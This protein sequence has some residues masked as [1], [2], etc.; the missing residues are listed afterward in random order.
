MRRIEKIIW[1]RPLMTTQDI[2]LKP[3]FISCAV[4]L[5][6]S[7]L[8]SLKPG[9]VPSDIMGYLEK[10]ALITYE[11]SIYSSFILLGIAGY[12]YAVRSI[13]ENE[14]HKKLLFYSLESVF[15]A[16]GRFAGLIL[17]VLVYLLFTSNYSAVPLGVVLL[18]YVILLT[19][20]PAWTASVVL[21]EKQIRRENIFDK[22]P[23]LWLFRFLCLATTILGFGGYV[24][25]ALRY[26]F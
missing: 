18:S 22:K 7:V 6:I 16:G 8:L 13:T 17:G 21:T 20:A 25:M 2:K 23:F 15:S 5:G 26:F 24:S 11:A 19:M 14:T 3:F 9:I 12:F 4:G 1:I 10:T